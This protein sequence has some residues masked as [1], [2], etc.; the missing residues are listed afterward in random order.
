MGMKVYLLT[1]WL[2]QADGK[3][4]GA[5]AMRTLILGKR[6]ISSAAVPAFPTDEQI[7]GG[8]RAL[9]RQAKRDGVQLG[10]ITLHEVPTHVKEGRWNFPRFLGFEYLAPGE[11]DE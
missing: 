4:R 3:E 2:S 8:V 5:F 10:S 6:P 11:P 9:K 1:A 7:A